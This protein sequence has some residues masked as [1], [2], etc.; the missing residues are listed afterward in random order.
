MTA[1][2]RSFELLSV[3]LTGSA[4]DEGVQEVY[5]TF[6]DSARAEFAAAGMRTWFHRRTG[7]PPTARTTTGRRADRQQPG[8]RADR[9]A[10]RAKAFAACSRPR[11]HCAPSHDRRLAAGAVAGVATLTGLRLDVSTPSLISVVLLGIG[12]DYLLFLL[13]RFLAS[14]CAPG[15]TSP[16]ARQPPRCPAGR[17]RDHLGRADHRGRLRHPGRGELR[18]FRSLGP[19]IAV[20]APIMLLG[21]LTLM[22][23]LL[24][25]CGRK[26]FWALPQPGPGAA[27][28][29]GCP[30]RRLR[31]PSSDGP[32]ARLR[33]APRR[34]RRRDDRDPDGLRP[35]R[36]LRGRRPR[37]PP[38]EIARALPA[39]VSDPTTV[40]ATA[41]DGGTLHPARLDGLSRALAETE[42]VGQVS[43]T[44][45]NKDHRAARITSS[46][47]ADPQSAHG[48]ATWSPARSAP[49]SPPTR[50]PGRAPTSAARRRSSPTSPSPWTTTW[51][52]SSRS[53]PP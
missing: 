13:F 3:E 5:R 47:T 9:P 30:L 41:A 14:T 24:A 37:Q 51:R 42:G 22:P 46:L 53:P 50:P 48:P 15:L 10:Q 31:R 25:A 32:A 52:S 21:S 39:G 33:R 8:H 40:D 1:P 43:G 44:A 29:R 11:C 7:R 12:V 6:R 4:V 49:P 35:G 27:G 19:A 2:D 34:P 16:P 17:H 20:A 26:M 23:A 45:R 28:G 18:Q 36:R 38:R